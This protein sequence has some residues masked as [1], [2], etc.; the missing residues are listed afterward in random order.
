MRRRLFRIAAA[1]I[2]LPSFFA[3]VLA[4]AAAFTPLPAELVSPSGYGGYGESLRFVDR[5][6]ALLREVRAGD[7][8]RARWV[9]LADLGEAAKKAMVAAEDRRF[10]IHPGV[11]PLSILRAIASSAVHRRV[12]SGASTLTMQLARLVRPHP[13]TLRGKLSEMALALRIEAS[14][15]KERILEEYVN[16]APFGPS[17]RGIDAASRYWFD[18]EPKELSL[19]EAATLASLPR[20]PDLYALNRHA[21]RAARRRDRVLSRMEAAGSISEADRERAASEPLFVEPFRGAFGAPHLVQALY[22][23]G[24]GSPPLRGL[25]DEVTTTV[26]RDLEREAE[27]ATAV[28]VRSLEARHVTA[29]SVVVL[30]NATGEVL[31]YVGAP[32]PVADA[33]GAW[34]DGVRALRQ[35]GS[36]LKPFVYGLA[37]ESLGFTAASVLPDVDLHLDVEGGVYTPLDYDERYHGPVRLREALGSS[38]NVP[39]VWTANELGP[40]RIVERLRQLG[41]TTLKE[42][43][44]YYG[45]AIAL[46]DGEVSLLELTNAYATIARGG[47]WKPVVTVRSAREKGAAVTLPPAAAARR[48]MPRAVAD[49]LAD[50]LADPDA[51]VAAFGSRSALELAFPVAAKTGTSKGFR[52]NWTIGFTREVTVGVWV[53]NFDGSAMEGVS[54]ISG[55]G[56]LFHDVMD[57]AMRGRTPAPL[58]IGAGAGA[59]NAELVRVAVCP[60]S[61]GTPT[62]ACPHTVR[63]WVPRGAH[64]E[65]CRMHEKVDGATVERFPP[66]YAAWAAS[67]GRQAA[68][69]VTPPGKSRP[70]ESADRVSIA[71]PRDGERLLL[72]PGRPRALQAIE[73]RTIAPAGAPR[74]TL[75]VDGRLA[76][77][78]AAPFVG[79]W[80]PVVGDHVLLAEAP[81][82]EAGQPVHVRVE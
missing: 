10:W 32:D 14:L 73:V 33:N 41:I 82:F 52:D 16:R 55:A 4:V 40:E 46:G 15:P 6:G 12:T 13:R 76:G 1:L 19:A 69:S 70:G 81:G 25:A 24:L 21:D 61:G 56:P 39:A 30:D 74:V 31:A 17:L 37:M 2:A 7:A 60:L 68:R 9:P 57:A 23:G 38:L 50:V 44:S 27:T 75:R 65:L 78:L 22:D 29:A 35:P 80:I 53:G 66:E 28:T 64:L 11:D 59:V 43:A 48:V 63:E 36:T 77:T 3:T 49:V 58:R 20:G 51:R 18:K 26:T 72:D 45:P 42:E 67:A 34:T 62:S 79:S 71:W 8:A 5:D 47:E 54:G